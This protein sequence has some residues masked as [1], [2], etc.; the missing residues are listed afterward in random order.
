VSVT[1]ESNVNQQGQ[2]PARLASEDVIVSAPMSYTGSAQRIMRLRRRVQNE[3]ALAWATAACVVL[4]ATAWLFVTVW[5][6]MWGF[7]LIPY[8]LIRR[9]ERKRKAEAL[10]HRE[11][12]AALQAGAPPPEP[13]P[14]PPPGQRVGDAERERTIDELRGHMLAGRLSSEE[15]EHRVGAVQKARTHGEILAVS[16]DL[17]TITAEPGA[18]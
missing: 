11:L 15:F 18:G 3:S 8:R 6:L 9:G 4:V 12:L 2:L 10:R 5:Y 17:P 1:E 13:V 16:D 7:L 14:K